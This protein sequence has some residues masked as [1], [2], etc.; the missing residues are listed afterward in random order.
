M[1]DKKFS[2]FKMFIIFLKIGAITIGGGLAMIPVIRHELVEKQKWVDEKEIVDLLAI[3]QS[4]PGVIAVNSSI[5]VGYKCAGIIGAVVAVVGVVLP[6]FVIILIIAFM[7]SNFADLW[8]V[9]KMFAGVRAGVTALIAIATYKLMKTAIT[10]VAGV[11]IAIA[12]FILLQ[13]LRVDI[14]YIVISAAIIG[15]V[16]GNF[17]RKTQ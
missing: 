16:I 10:D 14:A 17:K 5:Y 1:K 11:V 8:Y 4:L 9:Q 15:I 6:S 2:L 7:L 3:A 12:V 13:F